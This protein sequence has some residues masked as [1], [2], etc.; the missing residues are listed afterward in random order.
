M[1]AFLDDYSKTAMQHRFCG[2]RLSALKQVRNETKTIV[3]VLELQETH[4]YIYNT[5]VD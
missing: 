1:R 4:Y 3:D 2:I 5:D